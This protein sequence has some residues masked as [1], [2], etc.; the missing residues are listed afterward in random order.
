MDWKETAVAENKQT[1]FLI[2]NRYVLVWSGI[3]WLCALE[4]MEGYWELLREIEVSCGSSHSVRI[5]VWKE[6]CMLCDAV[7]ITEAGSEAFVLILSQIQGSSLVQRTTTICTKSRLLHSTAV[8]QRKF[9]K[10]F[11][12]THKAQQMT[13]SDEPA[14]PRTSWLARRKGLVHWCQKRN[15]NRLILSF[16]SLQKYF[17][18][19]YKMA[20]FVTLWNVE[21]ESALGPEHLFCGVGLEQSRSKTWFVFD[22]AGKWMSKRERFSRRL[23]SDVMHLFLSLLQSCPVLDCLDSDQDSA[24]GRY[25]AS[26]S[27]STSFS[28]GLQFQS[29]SWERSQITAWR[30]NTGWRPT[31]CHF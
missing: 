6:Y 14:D 9:F 27:M 3:L 24:P 25:Q 2:R 17:S 10:D 29:V 26:S 30:L 19:A 20:I 22:F 15:K 8:Q 18:V 1:S 12:F 4:I 28:P 16:Y 11:H 13:F 23:H 5:L 31:T 7:K 21:H